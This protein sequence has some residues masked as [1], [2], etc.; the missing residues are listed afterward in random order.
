M[1]EIYVQASSQSLMPDDWEIRI[2]L[3][4]AGKRRLLAAKVKS[5]SYK[6]ITGI[7]ADI[8]NKLGV[9]LEEGP[10]KRAQERL[11]RRQTVRHRP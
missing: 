1:R 3:K 2:A 11:R 5:V 6:I 4:L 9:P 10:L 7:G 8:T